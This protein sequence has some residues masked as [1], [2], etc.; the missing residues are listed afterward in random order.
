MNKKI[1]RKIKEIFLYLWLKNLLVSPN[2][3]NWKGDNVSA[4]GQS[5]LLQPSSVSMKYLGPW[6]RIQDKDI[7][8][9]IFHQLL[10]DY[11]CFYYLD[12]HL[13]S[14]NVVCVKIFRVNKF[15][16]RYLVSCSRIIIA[17]TAFIRIYELSWIV[18]WF[19]AREKS[20]GRNKFLKRYLQLLQENH[21]FWCLCRRP[22]TGIIIRFTAYLK[23]LITT[24]LLKRYL[25]AK[26]LKVIFIVACNLSF[27]HC[28]V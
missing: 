8:K 23:R 10:H 21:C 7:S 13:L 22:L 9:E 4:Q 2:L 11:H 19:T 5:L 17:F 24:N 14:I 28:D 6:K 12:Q 27:S 20:L 1:K 18:S 25:V 26:G 15:L 16:V 3:T